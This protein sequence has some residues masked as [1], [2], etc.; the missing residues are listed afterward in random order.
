MST[1]SDSAGRQIV[2]EH[3]QLNE[4]LEAVQQ[5]LRERQAD[6]NVVIAT[7]RELVQAILNHFEHE[8]T[9][10]YFAAVADANP[11]LGERARRLLLEHPAIADQLFALQ[12][13]AVRETSL[14]H[15]WEE[16]R[17]RF[18]DFWHAFATHEAAEDSLLQ[19]AFGDDIG[20]ED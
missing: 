12:L 17:R 11:Q 9:G 1:T 6:Q 18:D 2:E 15:C 7:L 3:R 8:E 5:M 13:C 10:G 16:L 20:A 14:T 4:I 19:E